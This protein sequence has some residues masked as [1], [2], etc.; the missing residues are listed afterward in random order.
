MKSIL[1]RVLR[2]LGRVTCG[3]ALIAAVVVIVALVA[4]LSMA[5]Q[6]PTAAQLVAAH[7]QI[8]QQQQQPSPSSQHGQAAQG[9]R[10]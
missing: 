4:V 1:T 2:A 6:R 5:L 7:D 3:E 9:V 8:F 10:P